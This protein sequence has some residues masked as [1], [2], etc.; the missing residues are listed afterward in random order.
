ML[1]EGDTSRTALF[2]RDKTV[3]NSG[4][5]GTDETTKHEIEKSEYPKALGIKM[6]GSEH[7]LRGLYQGDASYV[8]LKRYGL[9]A[10]AQAAQ[11]KPSQVP[12]LT[13]AAS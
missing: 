8:M 1:T 6:V 5:G 9:F 12:V 2:P 10:G 13:G 11:E 3:H 4:E 7:I